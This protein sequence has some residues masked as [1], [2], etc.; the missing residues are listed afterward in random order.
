MPI[1]LK[2]SK[3]AARRSGDYFLDQLKGAAEL[4]ITEYLSHFSV[5]ENWRSSHS[6]PMQSMLGYFRSKAFENDK[7]AIVVGD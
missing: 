3:K 6:Y 1:K 4:D 7:H 5:L 2:H